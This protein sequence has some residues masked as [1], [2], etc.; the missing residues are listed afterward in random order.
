M[1]FTVI[2]VLTLSFILAAGGVYIY[3]IKVGNSMQSG[4]IVLLK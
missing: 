1:K 4:K 3:T 2:I